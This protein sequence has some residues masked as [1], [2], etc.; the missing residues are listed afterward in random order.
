MLWRWAQRFADRFSVKTYGSDP[1]D[2]RKRPFP[3]LSGDLNQDG[4][5]DLAIRVQQFDYRAQSGH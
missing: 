4:I 3:W 5:P 2:S 1:Y